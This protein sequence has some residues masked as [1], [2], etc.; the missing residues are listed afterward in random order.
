MVHDTRLT[1][2]VNTGATTPGAPVTLQANVTFLSSQPAAR[3]AFTDTVSFHPAADRGQEGSAA[4]TGTVTF[5]DDAQV[6]GT[7]PLVDNVA[8]LT[9]TALGAGVH[10]ITASYNGL[11]ASSTSSSAALV[12]PPV[13]VVAE[14]A[15]TVIPIL[16]LHNRAKTVL[17]GRTADCDLP[18]NTAGRIERGCEILSSL[19]LPG[20]RVTYTVRYADDTTQTFTDTA[21]SRGH[22]LHAF[23]VAYLPKPA[24]SGLARAVV[25]V[26]VQAVLPDGTSAGTTSIRFA[27]Q[28]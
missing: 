14:K 5:K 28:R 20:A 9:T 23:N 10:H 17:G 16:V 18:G 27:A 24:K 1:I 22:S 6:L 2:S 4:A 11:T 8:T 19:W 15:G 26:D 13:V 12:T 25:L 21:D 3:E 7:V